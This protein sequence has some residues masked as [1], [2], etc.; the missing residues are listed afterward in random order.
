MENIKEKLKALQQENDNMFKKNLEFGLYTKV[1]IYSF[2][3]L[4]KIIKRME[5]KTECQ[6]LDFFDEIKYD[7]SKLALTEFIINSQSISK[8]IYNNNTKISSIEIKA[9]D[10][11]AQKS[12]SYARNLFI[13]KNSFS[14]ITQN[15]IMDTYLDTFIKGCN[16]VRDI[17]GLF[18]RVK[19]LK[20]D[21]YSKQLFDKLIKILKTKKLNINKNDLLKFLE[22][23]ELNNEEEKNQLNAILI[24]LKLQ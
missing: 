20:K 2:S 23:I 4:L 11:L 21:Y 17:T 6:L 3:S 5:I 9:F 12:M 18:S 7:I 22:T 24:S 19:I 8:I 1:N 16:N 13:R 15:Y 14:S 10:Y